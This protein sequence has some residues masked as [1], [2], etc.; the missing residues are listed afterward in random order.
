MRLKCGG[1][2]A[3]RYQVVDANPTRQPILAHR[4]PEGLEIVPKGVEE[5]DLNP[6]ECPAA[7]FCGGICVFGAGQ[8]SKCAPNLERNSHTS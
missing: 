5:E 7:L 1:V 6:F 2:S 3:A 8:N 4:D